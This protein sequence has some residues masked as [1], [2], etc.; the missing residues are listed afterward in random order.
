[1]SKSRRYIVS[2]S[3]LLAAI[4]FLLVLAG[5]GMEFG[6]DSS[7]LRVWMVGTESEAKTINEVGKIFAEEDGIKV[8]C[9][10]ISWGEA[11]SKYLTSMAGEVTPDIGAMGLTWATEFGN[12]GGMVDLN[13]EFP[14]DVTVMQKKIFPGLWE[15]AAYRGSVYGIPYDISEY[16]LYYRNDIIKDPP[17]TWK[18]LT[19]RLEDLK[20]RDMG[21]L[22]DWGSMNWIGYSNFLWQAGGDFYDKEGVRC[23]LDSKE[24]AEGMRFFAELYTKYKVPKASIPLEQGMRTGDFPMAI[25][26]NW[27]IIGLTLGAPEIDS[28]WSIATLPKGPSGKRTAFIGGRVM[29]I[30]KDS[31]KKEIAWKFIKFLS[32]PDIQVK[33][34]E[35]A[36][37]AQCMYLPPNMAAWDILPMDVEFR[38]ILKE[39]ALDAKGP[40]SVLGWDDSIRFIDQAIQ[41]VILEGS[42]PEYELKKVVA[43]IEKKVK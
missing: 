19:H 33:L 12:L 8:K 17:R 38:N 4:P 14:E 29:G 16:I 2:I 22:F 15:S 34:Y 5:C 41:R 7:V 1:M 3:L 28:K 31:K 11:H 20:K 32:R 9:D 24:A 39:Q 23:T 26:G 30:F 42:A 18:D 10:A 13:K 21:M 35:G 40:P 25:S 43:E 27:K 6:E 37:S 36:E